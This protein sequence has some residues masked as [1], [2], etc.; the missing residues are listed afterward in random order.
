[1]NANG[2]G[3]DRIDWLVMLRERFTE[4]AARRVLAEDVERVVS[5]AMRA[6]TDSDI[7]PGVDSIQGAPPVAWCF[8]VL[9]NTIGRYYRDEALRE[10]RLIQG[11][12][13]SPTALARPIECISPHAT[14]SL[15]AAAVEQMST[16]EPHCALFFNRFVEGAHPHEIIAEDDLDPTEFH[17]YLFGCRRKLRELLRTQGVSI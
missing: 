7:A 2:P 6:V 15:V 5:E 13:A 16:T 10:R 17:R 4:V 12:T 3:F 9:R 14:L 1:M 11:T 8:Q